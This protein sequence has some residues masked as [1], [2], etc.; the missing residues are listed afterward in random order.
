MK[1][2]MLVLILAIGVT[3]VAG[4]VWSQEAEKAQEK[5]AAPKLSEKE[6]DIR[7]L[8]GLMDLE[9]T[10]MEELMA[11][12]TQALPGVDEAFWEG[13]ITEEDMKEIVEIMVPLYD[14][15]FTHEEIK[16]VIEFYETPLGRTWVKKS[17]ALMKDSVK[18][19]QEWGMELGQRMMEKMM[20]EGVG[21]LAEA[22]R[23]GNET[24]AIGAL[25]TIGSVQAQFR[26]GDRE[27]DSMLDYATSLGELSQVGL[28]DNV[29]GSGKKSGYIFSLSGSTYEWLCKATPIDEATGDRNFI[30]CTD[31][32]VRFS[33]ADEATCRSAAIQ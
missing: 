12:M 9:A 24:A 17:T 6:K 15:H 20:E 21:P 30:V 11:S 7:K 31:G 14:K 32:V 3:A 18:A 8:L 13:L 2:C 23:T 16:G 19:M 33:T 26:E 1:S 28:I 5:K 27:N 25:R 22:R 4:G 10:T 29:L